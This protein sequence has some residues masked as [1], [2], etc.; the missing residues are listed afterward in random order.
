MILKD[1]VLHTRKNAS[2]KFTGIDSY[3]KCRDKDLFENF[4][5]DITYNYNSYGF[6]DDEWPSSVDELR[7]C[8]WC[9]GDSFTSGV[10]CPLEFTWVNILQRRLNK[11]CI[12]ISMDGASNGWISRKVK[13]IIDEIQPKII[14]VQW[15]YLLR[16]ENPDENLSDEDRRIHGF[17]TSP[18]KFFD[19]GL[20]T[21]NNMLGIGENT[22]T[23]IIHSFI[24]KSGIYDIIKLFNETWDVIA[25]AD[26]GSVP[27]NYNEYLNLSDLVKTEFS[28]VN[29]PLFILAGMLYKFMDSSIYV[30]EIDTLDL[31]RDGHHYSIK[32]ATKFVDDLIVLLKA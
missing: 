22:D 9:V 21:L 15:S 3:D 32:T 11:R 17:N 26:W 4:N 1:L 12:N 18:N 23:H 29:E 7:D 5:H 25:G 27:S 8:I 6:R 19:L 2:L 28:Q 30:K 20:T 13:R 16:D 10:G 14:I 31:A 24:P